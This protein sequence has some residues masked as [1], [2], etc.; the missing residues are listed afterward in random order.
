MSLVRTARAALFPAQ[1][2]LTVRMVVRAMTGDP[3]GGEGTKCKQPTTK[4]AEESTR[5]SRRRRQEEG[6]G[7]RRKKQ[8]EERSVKDEDEEQVKRSEQ[9]TL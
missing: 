7:G 2:T 3:H 6:G 9:T 5:R 8:Q 4:E 1:R